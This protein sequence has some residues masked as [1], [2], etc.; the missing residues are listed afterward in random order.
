MPL[1]GKCVVKLT[2]NVKEKRFGYYF[3]CLLN[4]SLVTKTEVLFLLNFITIKI[5]FY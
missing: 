3:H 1:N 2:D 5:M 4:N